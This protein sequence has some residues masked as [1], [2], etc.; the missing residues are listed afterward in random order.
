MPARDAA[1]I[2]QSAVQKISWRIVPFIGLMF[3]TFSIARRSPMLDQA[4]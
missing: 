2:E 3:F 4:A 1:A